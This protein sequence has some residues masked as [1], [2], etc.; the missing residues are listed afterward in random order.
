MFNLKGVASGVWWLASLIGQQNKILAIQQITNLRY[1]QLRPSKKAGS[2][3]ALR[4]WFSFDWRSSSA[5]AWCLEFLF[6]KSP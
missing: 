4:L 1:F 6:G 5:R 3:S 2:V